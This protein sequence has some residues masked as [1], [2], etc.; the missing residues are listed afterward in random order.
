M[1]STD[2]HP[3]YD[4]LNQSFQHGVVNHSAKQYMHGSIHTDTV[5]GFWSIVKRSIMGTFRKVS[6]KY[7]PQ[8][9]NEFQFRN[10]NRMNADIFGAA[11]WAC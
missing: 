4:D 8:Y 7:L 3:G 10:N 6:A 1:L 2:A 9:V 5:E 11:I